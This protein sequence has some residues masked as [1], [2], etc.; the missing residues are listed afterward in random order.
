MKR[1]L[2]AMSV[3]RSLEPTIEEDEATEKENEDKEEESIKEPEPAGNT[4]SM[5]ML[6][7]VLG[8]GLLEYDTWFQERHKQS[9]RK[10]EGEEKPVGA[11]SHFLIEHK[12]HDPRLMLHIAAFGG[13]E[14]DEVN[15][16]EKA[17]ESNLWE[18]RHWEEKYLPRTIKLTKAFKSF[19][20]N[21]GQP[22][23]QLDEVLC[24]G[25][26]DKNQLMQIIEHR[27]QSALRG[28]SQR[29]PK[30]NIW[31]HA[32]EHLGVRLPEEPHR[33]SYTEASRINETMSR[34]MLHADPWLDER[35]IPGRVTKPDEAD[36]KFLVHRFQ[37]WD[38][39]LRFAE[40]LKKLTPTAAKK[41]LK[42][43]D[44]LRPSS[45]KKTQTTKINDDADV[46]VIEESSDSDTESSVDGLD[47]QLTV[48]DKSSEDTDV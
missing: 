40:E 22:L 32:I 26:A 45:R 17:I 20:E 18:L 29:R 47:L 10:P 28:C 23:L 48:D 41:Q 43:H 12:L 19:K 15:P 46:V 39:K 37:L 27:F 31:D 6:R 2:E 34:A 44:L 42:E 16:Y 11:W 38:A 7:F 25:L 21:P 36:E 3:K 30:F 13:L 9:R 5:F 1:S 8:S 35:R 24:E 33:W 14:W 4:L